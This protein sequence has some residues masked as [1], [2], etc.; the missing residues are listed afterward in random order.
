MPVCLHADLS[1]QID[2]L[3]LSPSVT[4]QPVP[5]ARS[6]SF[7]RG[8]LKK[9]HSLQEVVETS[10][11]EVDSLHVSHARCVLQ[12]CRVIIANMVIPI[13]H[14]RLNQH[15]HSDLI[16]GRGQGVNVDGFAIQLPHDVIIIV[17]IKRRSGINPIPPTVKDRD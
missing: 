14:A 9:S 12:R 1:R 16:R 6:S 3:R 13:K 15:M 5:I 2:D 11:L 10:K 8:S 7:D 17:I 4:S